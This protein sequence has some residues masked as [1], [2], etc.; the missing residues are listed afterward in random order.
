MTDRSPVTI[1]P[2]N[3]TATELAAALHDRQPKHI[4]L[5]IP[6]IPKFT[7]MPTYYL[8]ILQLTLK[9]VLLN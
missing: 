4:E 8:L 3:Y 6:T 2:G 1:N 9:M 7:T 5:P